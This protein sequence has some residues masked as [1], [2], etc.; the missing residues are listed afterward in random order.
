MKPL[1]EWTNTFARC[2]LLCMVSVATARATTHYVV[3]AATNRFLR[4]RVTR[5]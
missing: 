4:L 5:P 1:A 3:I 2:A